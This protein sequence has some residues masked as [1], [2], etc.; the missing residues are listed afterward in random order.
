MKLIRTGTKANK[1]T[2]DA[3]LYDGVYYLPSTLFTNKDDKPVIH[4]CY[5]SRSRGK[6]LEDTF[7]LEADLLSSI[8]TFARKKGTHVPDLQLEL[9]TA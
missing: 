5:Y 8:I 3:V 2:V 7:I 6:W 1:F 9:D 4:G